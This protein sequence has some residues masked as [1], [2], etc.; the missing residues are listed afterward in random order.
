MLGAIALVLGLAVAMTRWSFG[1]YDDL[2]R[3]AAASN[4]AMRQAALALGLELSRTEDYEHPIVGNIPSFAN[5]RGVVDGARV[6][7]SVA[8]SSEGDTA[9]T[10]LSTELDSEVTHP[11]LAASRE[12]GDRYRLEQDGRRLILR[13]RLARTGSSQFITYEVV[14][15]P[16][17]LIALLHELARLAQRAR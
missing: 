1:R 17:E 13:P 2:R 14:T 4:E 3:V 7:I 11:A 9:N 10:E 15:D 12:A 5:V 8:R 16:G 6:M